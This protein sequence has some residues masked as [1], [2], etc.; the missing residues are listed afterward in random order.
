MAYGYRVVSDEVIFQKEA[1]E[2]T[3]ISDWIP[4]ASFSKERNQRNLMVH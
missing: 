2:W 1:I 3:K 4:A